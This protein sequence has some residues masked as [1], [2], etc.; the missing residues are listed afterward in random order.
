MNKYN[1]RGSRQYMDTM[2][3]SMMRRLFWGLGAAV[4]TYVV[5][6]K[7]RQ[8]AKPAIEKGVC[9]IKELAE[10]G[11]QTIEEYKAQKQETVNMIKD[12][13]MEQV[14]AQKDVISSKITALQ[15]TLDRLK[16]EIMDLRSKV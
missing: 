1:I 6:P 14:D 10:R 9:S 3:G 8:M 13:S 12:A 15:E 2:T 4:L 11:K 16:N 5:V 7:M